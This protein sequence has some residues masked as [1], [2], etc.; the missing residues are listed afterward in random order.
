MNPH[1]ITTWICAAVAAFLFVALP[2]W[3]DQ[4][5]L[6]DG[7]ADAG[8]TYASYGYTPAAL[9]DGQAELLD[10]QARIICAATH[11]PEGAT[12]RLADGSV[13]CSTKHGRGVITVLSHQAQ[14]QH[15]TG[16]IKP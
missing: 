9:D 12:V 13:R 10:A 8:R 11:G 15:P 6:L 7:P 14:H 1:A 2:G 5:S 4:P 16:G 3:M